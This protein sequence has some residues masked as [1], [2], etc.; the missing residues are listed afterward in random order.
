MAKSPKT[1]L[2]IVILALIGLVSLAAAGYL[3]AQEGYTVYDD[4]NPPITVYGYYRTVGDVVEASELELRPEDSIIPAPET[5]ADAQTGIKIVRAK[6]VTVHTE[7]GPTTYFSQAPHLAAFLA[8]I[9]FNPQPTDQI[10]ADGKRVSF[11]TLAQ[12]P[13]PRK[14]EIGQ[15]VT[16]QIEEGSQ[17]QTLRTKVQTVGEAL[18]EAG[19]TLFAADKT[20]PGLGAWLEPEMVIRVQRSFPVTIQVDG[21]TVSTRTAQEN[22]LNVLA[23]NGI[24]LIGHDYTIPGPEVTLH[25]N[26]TIQVIRVTED[27]RL[28][29]EAIP[30][31][32][33]YQAND[34]IDIDSQGIV[35]AGVPGIKRQRI[36][37]RYEN[38]VPV[39]EFVD[40]EWVAS[41][42]VN[43]VIGYGTK[44]TIRTL[45]TPD[46]P[47]EYWRVVRMR[48]TAYTAASSG[49]PIDH[50]G[51]GITA[52]GL[53]AGKGVVAIDRN[54]VPW[55]SWLYVPGYGRAIAGDTGGG[56]RGRWIDLGYSDDD[57][58]SWSG[59]VDVYYLTPVPPAEDINF[60]IPTVLP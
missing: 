16:V 33:V 53:P 47:M 12:R 32:T 6:A 23:E 44:I 11:S 45:D 19:I 7:A 48:V 52:S 21:R 46:G 51:Y 29:D 38:G 41:E 36:R 58:E 9:G 35:S 59:Y 8:E 22:A 50:P 2:V 27:F 39:D 18:Q 20:E 40:G 17:R 60:L 4:A 25:P 34:Q 37:V 13:L 57:F 5:L 30:Y 26:N 42:P 49:K 3:F 10:F 55:K 28:E 24:G 54:V 14:V 43:E 31:Q 56:V 15:F 1:R